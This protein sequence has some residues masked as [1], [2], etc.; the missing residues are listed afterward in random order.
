MTES[1]LSQ[2]QSDCNDTSLKTSLSLWSIWWSVM[3]LLQPA[4]SY[5][6]TFMWFAVVVA[7]ITVRTDKLGVSSIMRALKLRDGC[8]RSLLKNFHSSAV[9]LDE[10]SALWTEVALRLFPNPVRVN[11]RLILV[12][13]GTKAAKFGKRMPAVK[14]IHQ[15]SEHK[16]DYV[17]GH[18]LQ[19]VALLVHSAKSIVAV[20]LAIRIHEGIVLSNFVKKTLIDKM[21]SLLGIV[22]QGESYYFVGDRYYAVK[23][24]ANA[25]LEAGNHL[26]TR[27]RVNAVAYA[28]PEPEQ[29]KKRGRPRKY[30]KEIALASLFKS[31][32]MIQIASPVYGERDVMLRYVVADLLWKPLK[33]LVRFVIVVHPSRGRWILMTTDTTLDAIEIIRTYGLRFKIEFT[34]KQAIHQIGLFSY[35][36]W[37]KAMTPLKRGS[38]NQYLHRKPVKYRDAVERKI[39]AYHV[40]MQACVIAQGLSQYLAAAFP[41]LVWASF[42]SWL[43][44][45]R[46][47]V[48]PSEFVVAESLRQSLPNFL[49]AGANTHAFAKFTTERQDLER[50]EIFSIAA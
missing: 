35:H 28:Q 50:A 12:G 22:H 19:A 43:R 25:L 34:F 24:L 31:K 44:T 47:G 5:L 32:D 39:H 14:L 30:G 1:I 38:G 36:F 26:L 10:L 18:S 48:P 23:K 16:P 9:R 41:E 21:F 42:R 27:V 3:L 11:G 40:F 29:E 7:G 49:L 20:P 13:D 4:F 2:E 15:Y 17:M 6:P 37:M 33:R 46:P 8:Y 45:I